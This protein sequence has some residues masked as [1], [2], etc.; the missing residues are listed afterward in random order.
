MAIRWLFTV[1]AIFIMGYIFN[2]YLSTEDIP[3]E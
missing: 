2:R 3:S 1:I